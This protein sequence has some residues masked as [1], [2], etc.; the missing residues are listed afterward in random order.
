VLKRFGFILLFILM[1]LGLYS[2]DNEA[3]RDTVAI[4]TV[5]DKGLVKLR[6][7]SEKRIDEFRNDRDYN[8]QRNPPPP[9]NP[10]AKF[11]YWLLDKLN[12]FFQGGSYQNFWQYV[13]LAAIGGTAIWL[14]YK[15]NFSGGFFGKKPEE[16]ALAYNRITE[17]IHELD[18]NS[19]LEEALHQKNYRLAVRL[20]YLK[21]LKQL[22]DKQ[23]IHWQPT[24]TNRMYVHELAQSPLKMDFERLTSQFEYIWYGEFSVSEST[25]GAIKEEFQSF[26][27]SINLV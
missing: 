17:N 27:T 22:T 24:K 15:A 11:W 13:L 23:L 1:N 16:D 10:L 6:T 25:F 26:S 14:L 20:Y 5:K 8:Y 19:S 9:E 12:S 3:Q 4:S 7:P 2:Q 18:F 21:A